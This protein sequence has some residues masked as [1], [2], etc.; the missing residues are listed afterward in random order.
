[1]SNLFERLDASDY[2]WLRDREEPNVPINMTARWNQLV[3]LSD[4][5][6]AARSRAR[7]LC[8]EK[9][10]SI[11]A[12]VRQ[13]VRVRHRDKGDT[14][15]AWA[16]RHERG[17]VC[18]IKYRGLGPRSTGKFSEP[19]SRIKYPALPSL[20]CATAD[21]SCVWVAEGETDAAWLLDHAAP[22][23]GVLCNHGGARNYCPEWAEL[24]RDVPRVVIATDKDE[25]GEWMAT[26]YMRDLGSRVERRRS[27]GKDWCAS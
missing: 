5:E 3:P 22:D 26:Q 15:L 25:H 9:N 23:E 24:L 20:Y 12:L 11:G 2:M 21:P 18:G 14:T 4:A 16:V 13:G 8:E 27:K 10:F 6:E 19:G 1:V 7:R 17:F